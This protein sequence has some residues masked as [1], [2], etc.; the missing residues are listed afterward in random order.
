[1]KKIQVEKEESGLV[2][3]AQ[4]VNSYPQIILKLRDLFFTFP[5]IPLSFP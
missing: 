2:I 3:A 4:H 1:M 5:F